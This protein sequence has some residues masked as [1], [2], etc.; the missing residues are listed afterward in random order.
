MPLRITNRRA[1]GAGRS[2][3]ADDLLAAC[4]PE[5]SELDLEVYSILARTVRASKCLVEPQGGCL[6]GYTRFKSFIFR[7]APLSYRM[8]IVRY[9]YT[10][11]GDDCGFGEAAVAL[12]FHLQVDAGGHLTGGDVQALPWCGGAV[13][14][15]CSNAGDPGFAVFVL[16]PL[17]PG[18]DRQGSADFERAAHLNLWSQGDTEHNILEDTVDWEDLLRGTA[19][20]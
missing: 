12:I 2:L 16:P 5:V 15:G 7:G 14:T 8:N 11:E 17:R 9:D 13:D 18:I 20:N 10:C 19:W 3:A 6:S 4:H 1:A